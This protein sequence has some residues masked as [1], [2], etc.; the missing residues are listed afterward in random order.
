MSFSNIHNVN[1][2]CVNGRSINNPQSARIT[3]EYVDAEGEK[4]TDTMVSRG[5]NVEINGDV[6][7][8]N[9]RNAS[10]TVNGNVAKDAK[11][12]NGNVKVSG[13]IGGNVSTSNGNVMASVIHGSSRTNNRF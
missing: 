13:S 10:L 3:V 7:E 9:M 11:T 8:V 12:T 1:S 6:G 5:V 2:F 4:H